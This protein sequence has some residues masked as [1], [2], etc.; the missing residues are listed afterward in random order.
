MMSEVPQ[1]TAL[2]GLVDYINALDMLCGLAQ[3]SLFVFEK[4]FD[5]TGFNSAARHDVL[6]DFL[7]ANPMNRLQL[8]AHDTGPLVQRC[9]RMMLLLRQF[10]HSMQIY[11]TP[12]HLRNVSEPFAVADEL[13]YVRRFHFDDPRGIL[14]RHDAEGARTLRSRFLEMWSSSRPGAS[15]TTLGL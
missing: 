3:R 2:N 4:D 1:H 6:R 5:G 9:P 11:R 7:L 14:A 15:A 12:E 13:H 10:S 8:L